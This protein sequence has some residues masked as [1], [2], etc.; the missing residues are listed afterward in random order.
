V[1]TIEM[2]QGRSDVVIRYKDGPE[3]HAVVADP[4]TL[5]RNLQGAG[6]DVSD[7]EPQ[8]IVSAGPD[9][10]SVLSFLGQMLLVFLVGLIVLVGLGLLVV[11]VRRRS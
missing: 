6:V 9:P 8:V 4:T 7:G 2:R 5:L 11:A 3:A 10:G 1:R